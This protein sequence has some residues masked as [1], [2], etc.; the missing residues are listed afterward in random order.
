[1]E[2][3]FE[4][5]EAFRQKAKAVLEESGIAEVWKQAGCRVEIVGSMRM[6]LMARHR[7]IDLH[8]Y[9]PEVT[10]E[11]SFK[12]AAIIAGDPRVKEIKCING[13]ATDEHCIAWH[14]T[15]EPSN[16][17]ENSGELWQF[18]VIHIIKGSRYDGFF[19]QMA[20]RIV[21]QATISQKETI[22][23]LKFDTPETEQIH[24]VEYYEAVIAD[25][26]TTLDALRQWVVTRRARPFYYWMP[27]K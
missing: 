2:D 19:E 11:D 21:N 22:L 5:A 10:E 27:G 8:V 24:G 12:V 26:V 17:K 13:L 15:Y 20:D 7:D 23:R 4:K 1:M 14:F 6:G 18:D 9:S 16:P 3:V 25:G